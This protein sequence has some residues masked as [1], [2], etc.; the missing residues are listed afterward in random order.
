MTDGR[1][2]GRVPVT[3]GAAPLTTILAPAGFGKSTLM[4]M[5]RSRLGRDWVTAGGSFDAFHHTNAL[6]AGLVLTGLARELGVDEPALQAALA[7]VPD[8][9]TELGRA[10]IGRLGAALIALPHRFVCFLDDLQ[11]LPANVAGDLGWLVSSVADD[12][13]RFVVASRS[14]LSWPVQRW[15]VSGFADVV[16][17]DDLL[18]S[19]DDIAALFGPDLAHVARRAHEVTGGWA[20]AVEMLRSRLR[21]M[22]TLKVEDAVLD[23]ADY[24]LAEVLP[25]LEP[26]GMLVLSR[27]SILDAFTEPVAV[28]ISGDPAALRILEDVRRRTSLITRTEEGT[29]RYHSILREALHRHLARQEPESLR[30]LHVRAAEAWLEEP[31]SFATFTHAVEHLVEARSWQRVLDLASEGVHELDRHGRIDLLVRW[32]D[33]VP[34][35]Y[36][37]NDGRQLVLYAWASLRI[38]NVTGALSELQRPAITE[39]PVAAASG[40]LVYGAAASWTVDPCEAMEVCERALPTMVELDRSRPSETPWIPGVQGYELAAEWMVGQAQIYLGRFGDA[41]ATLERVLRLRVGIS[42]LTQCSITGALAFAQAIRG[43]IAA[44]RARAQESL[45]LASDAGL[46][47]RSALKAFALLALALVAQATGGEPDEAER[48][49]GEA[50]A[51]CRPTRMVNFLHLCDLVG[52]MCGVRDSF[53]AQLEPT[54]AAAPLPITTQATVAAD[55]RRRAR[56]GDITG[57]ERQLGTVMPDEFTLTAWVEVLL[58][59]LERRQVSTWVAKRSAPTCPRGR[60]LRLLS[61]AATAESRPTVTRLVLRAADLAEPEGLVG[62]LL[63]APEQMWTRLDTDHTSHPLLIEAVAR[64]T[65]ATVMR[66]VLTA[67]ELEVLR[68]LP[69]TKT[70]R[71]LADR[72]FVSVNTAKWHLANIY[73][74]L[75]AHGRAAAIA[76]A[77]E[78]KLIDPDSMA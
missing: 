61:E 27:T 57:A 5:W 71:D 77:V 78:F 67:R 46:A 60:V 48:L 72:L 42:P 21:A 38:G 69:Y 73:R 13:R 29:Y 35:S 37:R 63:D 15:R 74:K 64:R 10:F 44:A 22:P 25:A 76:R 20:A 54:T 75:G 56:L 9:G 53:G 49:V 1:L 23:L 66:P 4:R 24:V 14:E 70:A 51:A 41:A 45:Q 43:D 62:L 40:R 11:A 65:E 36:W 31:D 50:A 19:V 6:D 8:D 47:D 2:A 55:A 39:D 18:L 68:I 33:S 3:F 28:A 58:Y 16:V 59:R 7:L 32:F 34:G 12:R 17:A 26:R 30:E 52:A